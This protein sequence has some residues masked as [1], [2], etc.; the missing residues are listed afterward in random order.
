MSA[1]PSWLELCR[2]QPRFN[3]VKGSTPED[4]FL[5]QAK[6]IIVA[7]GEPF[8][9]ANG[10]Y[11]VFCGLVMSCEA[12]QGEFVMGLLPRQEVLSRDL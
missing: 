7:P 3:K 1:E 5:H 11:F 10:S 12:G 9:T 2:V 8:F 6:D 4:R